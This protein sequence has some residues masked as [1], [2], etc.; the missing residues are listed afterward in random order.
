LQSSITAI[1]FEFVTFKDKTK[2]LKLT[3]YITV[4]KINRYQTIT[5]Q[6]F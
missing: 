2:I 1:G 5:K 4:L 3:C 6:F